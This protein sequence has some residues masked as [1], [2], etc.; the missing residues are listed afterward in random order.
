M[1]MALTEKQTALVAN[2]ASAPAVVTVPETGEAAWGIVI[3]PGSFPNDVDGNYLRECG[4]P[5]NARPHAYKD[6][7]Q[8]LAGEGCAVLRYARG[9]VTT[10]DKDQAAAHRHFADRTAVVVEAVRVL[11]TIMPGLEYCALA[12]H[13][14]GGP[15]CLLLMT[16]DEETT[17]IGIDAYISLSAPARRIFDIM[18][19]QTEK[20]V[21]DGMASF[22]PMTFPFSAYKRALNLVR[23]GQPVPEEL[24]RQL[25]AMGVYAMDEA[26]KLYL[27]EYDQINSEKL[28]AEIPFPVLI[29]QGEKD[30]SV[31]PDN[32]EMLLR[33][34][35]GNSAPTEIALF[36]DL[37]HFYKAVP[38]GLDPVM[39][40]GLET[41]SDPQ[42][43]AAIRDWLQRMERTW[44]RGE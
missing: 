36:P 18:L 13:S 21:R 26:S 20:T 28:I 11:R 25:P 38:P 23:E 24:L 17:E 4:S 27:R 29:V 1:D 15:V 39:A 43:A 14:E 5:F 2:G 31:Y 12:G 35:E 37:Q 10:L 3:V 32:A 30:T 7:A 33:A 41:E 9:G 42:V 44:L 40:F 22:G 34:R 8:Q 6:L 16:Q 19:E